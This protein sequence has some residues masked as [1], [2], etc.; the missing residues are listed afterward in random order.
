MK[1]AHHMLYTALHEHECYKGYLWAPFDTLLNVPRLQ[2][3]NQSLFWYHSPWGRPVPNP[4]FGFDDNSGTLN[5]SRHAPTVNIS[6]DP[7]LNLTENWRGWGKDW[8]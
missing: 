3:F 1:M 4:A 8:W 7:S 2:Q 5:K 6:P